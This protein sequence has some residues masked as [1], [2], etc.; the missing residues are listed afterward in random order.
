M[1]TIGIAGGC[2][3]VGSNLAQRLAEEGHTVVLVDNLMRAGSRCNLERL[4]SFTEVRFFHA[5]VRDPRDL[6]PLRNCDALI[7]CAAQTSVPLAEHAPAHNF[8]VNTLGAFNMLELAREQRLPLVFFSSNKVYPATDLNALPIVEEATRFRWDIH[9]LQRSTLP[10]LTFDGANEEQPIG[11]NE[12]WPLGIGSRSLYGASKVAADLLCQEYCDAFGI[13]VFINRCSCLAG[14]W[15]YG[16]AAQGWYVWFIIAAQFQ[17]PITYYGWQGKQVRDV[18]FA[19][20]LCD[21][22][23]CQLYAALEGRSTGG[24]YNVGGG[25]GNALSLCEHVNSLTGKGLRPKV[26]NGSGEKRRQDQVI[27]ITDTSSVQNEF[28]WEP[29]INLTTGLDQC[30]SW[31]HA[32]LD[33]VRSMCSALSKYEDGTGV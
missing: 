30:I 14:P 31:V 8:S 13:P 7:N 9:H 25:L 29:Q 28:S 15:Q 32:N 18:L 12:K 27:Y 16:Q 3:F 20:D 1:S 21:L 26:I 5:D 22:V 24:V 6:E 11:V 19:P 2:G 23:L 10:G 17:L 33:N 4:L